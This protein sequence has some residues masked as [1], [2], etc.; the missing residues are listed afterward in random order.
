MNVI[1]VNM[2][3]L[4]AGYLLKSFVE[5]LDGIQKKEKEVVTERI[6][7]AMGPENSS[8][9]GRDAFLDMIERMPNEMYEGLPSDLMQV[10]ESF[11]QKGEGVPKPK[12][13]K[14]EAPKK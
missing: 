7:Y 11:K 3:V 9:P 6:I 2:D 5:I 8:G 4:E 10:I 1:I 12:G 14:K 13:A